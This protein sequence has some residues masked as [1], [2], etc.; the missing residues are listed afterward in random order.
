M[1]IQAQTI[2]SPPHTTS[3]LIDETHVYLTIVTT[4]NSIVI[5]TDQQGNLWATLVVMSLF[6][7]PSNAADTCDEFWKCF[8]T[9]VGILKSEILSLS[10]ADSSSA[11]EGLQ[12]AKQRLGKLQSCEFQ[13]LQV[14]CYVNWL[15]M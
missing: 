13:Q 8:N 6:E 1:V 3:P 12:S 15:V 9:A 5:N 4:Q 2:D 7:C 11:K 14:V 10:T